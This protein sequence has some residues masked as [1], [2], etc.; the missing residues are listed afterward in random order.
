MTVK[1]KMSIDTETS[2]NIH[3]PIKKWMERH[4]HNDYKI[5]LPF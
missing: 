5:L 2:I 4:L 3:L 1:V